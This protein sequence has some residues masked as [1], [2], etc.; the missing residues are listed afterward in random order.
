MVMYG[1]DN[2]TDVRAIVYFKVT[3]LNCGLDN[4]CYFD[5]MLYSGQ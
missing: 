1:H 3:G 5:W 2:K 4:L